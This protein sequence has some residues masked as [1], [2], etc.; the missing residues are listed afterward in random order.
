METEKI[1][2]LNYDICFIDQPK[3]ELLL[4]T[5]H[6]F[7]TESHILN[8]FYHKKTHMIYVL[9]SKLVFYQYKTENIEETVSG[10]IG[11][12]HPKLTLV[13][14]NRDIPNNLEI[15]DDKRIM[16]EEIRG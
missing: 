6:H 4:E 10:V 15:Q 14:I 2:G 9:T 7:F 13:T 3:F 16:K 8:W 11:L 5:R 1:D 12:S